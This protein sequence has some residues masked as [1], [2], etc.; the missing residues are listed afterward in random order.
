MSTTVRAAAPISLPIET[1][2]QSLRDLTRAQ[3]Y[4]PGLTNTTISTDYKEGLGAS[5]IV[6]HKQFGEMDETVIR[7][8]E[9]QGFTVRLHKGDKAARPFKRASFRYE[10]RPI[11]NS[12]SDR[13]RC[14]IHTALV[15][16]LPFGLI[17]RLFD[18][19]LLGRIFRLSVI[20]TAVCLAENYQT[21]QPVPESRRSQLRANALSSDS[22][23]S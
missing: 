4:V 19:L 21:G 7:W 11:S 23:D 22:S 13:D 2:W 12:P 8:D 5:R 17:G 6:T 14:E 3:H 9:G 20:D 10:L 1:C 16:E 18:R 15:Y